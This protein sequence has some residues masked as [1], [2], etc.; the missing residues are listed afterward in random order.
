MRV[1]TYIMKRTF[2]CTC[3]T[4]RYAAQTLTEVYDRGLAPSGL[5]VTQYMLLQSIL[6][7]ETEQSITELAQE[8]GSDRST[9]GR[10]LRILERDGFVTVG[11]GFDRREHVIQVTEKGQEAVS[12]AYPLWQKAQAA[13]ADALGQD[14]LEKLTTLLSLLQETSS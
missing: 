6:R 13:V 12:R 11:K 4:V 9:I 7:S 3:T 1:Y 8:L 5:R 10:N 14:Q 2:T